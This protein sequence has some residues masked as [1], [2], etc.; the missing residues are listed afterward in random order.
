MGLLQVLYV[1]RER[2]PGFKASVLASALETDQSEMEEN[3]VELVSKELVERNE[4]LYSITEKGYLM[5]YQRET[6]YCPHL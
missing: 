6:S 3:L 4:D 5:V 1:N 2:A